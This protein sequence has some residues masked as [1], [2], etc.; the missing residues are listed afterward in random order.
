MHALGARPS[1]RAIARHQPTVGYQPPP[2]RACLVGD[3]A[4]AGKKACRQLHLLGGLKRASSSLSLA[5]T[6]LLTCTGPSG[7]ASACCWPDSRYQPPLPCTQMGRER[8]HQQP[9]PLLKPKPVVAPAPTIMS[10]SASTQAPAAG[11]YSDTG[12]HHQLQSPP[13]P[14]LVPSY[15]EASL[16]TPTAPTATEDLSPC[17]PRTTRDIVD[18]SRLSSEL[19]RHLAPHPRQCYQMPHTWSPTQLHKATHLH[20]STKMTRK[21]GNMTA[22]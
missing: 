21:Q 7:G 2:Q 22:P 16:R 18:P 15:L 10:V 3:R 12:A 5:C 17:L 19:K 13:L 4:A 14:A 11:P 20:K 6:I 8:A 1:S 9:G